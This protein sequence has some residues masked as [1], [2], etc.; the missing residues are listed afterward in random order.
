MGIWIVVANERLTDAA[1]SLVI[2]LSQS[3]F[4]ACGSIR[5][6]ASSEY[7]TK[8]LNLSWFGEMFCHKNI[9]FLFVTVFYIRTP[10]F[11]SCLNKPCIKSG[12]ILTVKSMLKKNIQTAEILRRA[13]PYMPAIVLKRLKKAIFRR[14][15]CLISWKN[16]KFAI[17]K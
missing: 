9:L 11:P 8:S 6:S 1:P 12:G 15:P 7:S 17:T 14:F 4:T 5:R 3:G 13:S 2:E 10:P 16:S